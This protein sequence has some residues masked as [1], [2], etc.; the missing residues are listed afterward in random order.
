MSATTDHGFTHLHL[1][2]QYSLLDGAI[3][4]DELCP[5]VKEKGMSAEDRMTTLGHK[6]FEMTSHYDQEAQVIPA[7]IEIIEGGLKAA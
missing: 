6:N 3:R 5:T 4:M 2:T 1:H 7:S